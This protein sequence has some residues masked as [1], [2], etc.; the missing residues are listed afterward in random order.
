MNTTDLTPGYQKQVQDMYKAIGKS[1]K[2]KLVSIVMDKKKGKAIS[3]LLKN[4][5]TEGSYGFTQGW[6]NKTIEEYGV[7][8][9]PS[10]WL[11]SPDAK[12]KILLSQ[13]EFFRMARVKDSITDIVRDRIEGKDT[14][15]L[16][17]PPDEE[18][19]EDGEDD[20]KEE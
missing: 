7:R 14:P 3:W 16:A 5:F 15:T 13:H 20:D 6:D 10:G 18:Q 1:H 8:S 9:T 4:K 19:K 17:T 11:I 12:R 2:V